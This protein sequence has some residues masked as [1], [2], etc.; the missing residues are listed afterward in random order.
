MIRNLLVCGVMMLPAGCLPTEPGELEALRRNVER[1]EARGLSSYQVVLQRA[2]CECLPEWLVPIRLTVRD[3]EVQ[4]VINL[5]T[6]DTVTTELY[7]AMT[8]DELFALVENALTQNAYRVSVRYDEVLGYPRS[9]FIDYDRE[10]VDDELS[11]TAQELGPV[12]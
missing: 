1:W 5:Q 9:I 12:D 11:I 6:G 7:H 4:S 3:H 10:A 2:T 8:V